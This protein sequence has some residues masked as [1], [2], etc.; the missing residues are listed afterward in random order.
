VSDLKASAAFYTGAASLELDRSK[1]L[2]NTLAEAASG[3]ANSPVDRVVLAGPNGYLELSQYDASLS[4]PAE[5]IPVQGPGITHYCFQA[6][7]PQNLYGRFKDLGATPVS[8]GTE[9]VDLGGYGVYYA[10]ERDADGIMF[11][12]EHFDEPHFEGPI[13]LSHIAL[14]TPDIDRL[15]SF[16]QNLIGFEP[17]RRNDN[18]SG[19]RADEVIDHDGTIIRAAW[20]NMSNMI[21]ELW[22]FVNPQ[23]PEVGEPIPFEKIGYNKFAF[24]VADIQSDYKRLVE[25]GVR[26]L[27]EP[28]QSDVSTEVFGRDPDGNLF[29]L[30]QPA[31]DSGISI[32]TMKMR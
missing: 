20:F 24:E 3:F 28:V 12:T 31:A 1:A 15:V 14:V 32:T 23:T 6:P 4:G 30:I 19:P 27:S 26:F 16:Y 18:V 25:S 17:T 29:S 11:E 21:L 7:V 5:E 22:Q 2:S 13:W 8:R 10:Y 9:P